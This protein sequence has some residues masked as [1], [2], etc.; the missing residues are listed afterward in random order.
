MSTLRDAFFC[1]PNQL[2]TDLTTDADEPLLTLWRQLSSE[3]SER[4]EKTVPPTGLSVALVT[5]GPSKACALVT[6]PLACM[7]EPNFVA[8]VASDTSFRYL[9]LVCPADPEGAAAGLGRMYEWTSI[10]TPIDPDITVPLSPSE[11]AFA[12]HEYVS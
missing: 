6:M 7:G 1:D 12:V 10:G 3:R 9:T 11:F 2:L 8:L 5:F 4:G